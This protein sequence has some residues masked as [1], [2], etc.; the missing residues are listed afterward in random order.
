MSQLL[1]LVWTDQPTRPNRVLEWQNW[2]VPV[3]NICLI[4]GQSEHLMHRR[5]ISKLSKPTNW[6]QNAVVWNQIGTRCL[7]KLHQT[8]WVWRNGTEAEKHSYHIMYIHMLSS[9]H[10]I[11]ILILDL[12]QAHVFNKPMVANLMKRWLFKASARRLKRSDLTTALALQSLL[13]KTVVA[14]WDGGGS[15]RLRHI[16]KPEGWK[17]IEETWSLLGS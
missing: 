3:P 1:R 11:S 17:C 6:S 7:S 14:K 13:G 10:T 5:E 8:V 16:L 4:T 15:F 9:F 12:C 2:N